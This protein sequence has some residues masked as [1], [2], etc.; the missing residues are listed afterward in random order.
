[1]MEEGEGGKG[2]SGRQGGGRARGRIRWRMRGG[3]LPHTCTVHSHFLL[4]T[5]LM[6]LPTRPPHTRP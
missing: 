1:M 6:T 5:Y 4:Q 3:L 2:R